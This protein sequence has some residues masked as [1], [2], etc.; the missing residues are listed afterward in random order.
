M[1]ECNIYISYA[2]LVS[3]TVICES[4]NEREKLK[5][6]L[7]Q[8]SFT[9]DKKKMEYKYNYFIRFEDMKEIHIEKSFKNIKIHAYD[10]L[11]ESGEEIYGKMKNDTHI[12]SLWDPRYPAYIEYDIKEKQIVVY[13]KKQNRGQ[14]VLDLLRE[15]FVQKNLEN[16]QFYFLKGAAF[17]YH[18]NDV[19]VLVGKHGVGKTTLLLELLLRNKNFFFLTN[20]AS[21]IHCNTLDIDIYSWRPHMRIRYGTTKIQK[22]ERK[23]QKR[24]A[25]R[26]K[27][28]KDEE[29]FLKLKTYHEIEELFDITSR[30][31]GKLK[32][33]IFL[34]QNQNNESPVGLNRVTKDN[35]GLA[36]K[37]FE[38]NVLVNGDLTHPDIWQLLSGV[39]EKENYLKKIIKD[40]EVYQLRINRDAMEN[41]VHELEKIFT[42]AF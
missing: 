15:Q 31:K 19:C 1:S 34:E 20:S 3:V 7:E 41:C 29:D 22:V 38:K 39:K 33:I 36:L 30:K 25:L 2:N 14:V 18:G 26:D 21:Y 13:S 16:N 6:I 27:E 9:F 12:F 23:I 32:K 17:I 4:E 37:L 35:L 24:F 11:R 5:R 28:Y 42:T 8:N 10:N 40:C